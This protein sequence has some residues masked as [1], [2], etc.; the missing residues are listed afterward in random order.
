[1]GRMTRTVE[2]GILNINDLITL[3]PSQPLIF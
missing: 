3:L 2:L 1:M